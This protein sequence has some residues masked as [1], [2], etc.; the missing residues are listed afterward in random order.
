LPTG[1]TLASDGTLSG[2]PG[3]TGTFD[4]V[5]TLAD[6]NG[7]GQSLSYS[8]HVACATITLAPD[9][10]PQ[11]LPNVFYD[12]TIT[13]TGGVAPYTFAVTSGSLPTGLTLDPNT[14]E[15][16]GTTT[17]T[18]NFTFTVTVT[19]AAGCTGSHDYTLQGCLFCADFEDGVLDTGWTYTGSWSESGGNLIGNAVSGKALAVASPVF[20]GCS[21]CSFEATVQTAGGIGNKVSF[22]GWYQDSKNNVEL[23]MKQE[24]GRWLLKQHINGVV[25]TKGKAVMTINPNQSYLV[26]MAFDGTTFTVSIDGSPAITLTA[27]G[28]ASGTGAFQGKKTTV[29]IG[30]LHVN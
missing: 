16:S 12:A 25:V 29:T 15:L 9:T 5:V 1:L 19:D 21:T 6:A 17:D 20:S 24:S 14:G 2:T 28:S 18:G 10:L 7:C 23:M 8:I 26:H 13:P 3:A 27:A 22:F 30:Y 11:L 4:F